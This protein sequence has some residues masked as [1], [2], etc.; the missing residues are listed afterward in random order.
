MDTADKLAEALGLE[1]RQ[2]RRPA[3]GQ[4]RAKKK[5]VKPRG[6]ARKLKG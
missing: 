4:E 1:L 3:A 5:E 6:E 2:S